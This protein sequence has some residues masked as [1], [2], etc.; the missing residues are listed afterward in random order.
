MRARRLHGSARA[1]ARWLHGVRLATCLVRALRE[2]AP[3]TVELRVEGALAVAIGVEHI[4]AVESV[5]IRAVPSL[6]A[7]VGPFSGAVLRPDGQL[8]LVLDVPLLAARAWAMAR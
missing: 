7:L 8:K 2:S 3:V 4:A 5:A 1:P 6:I